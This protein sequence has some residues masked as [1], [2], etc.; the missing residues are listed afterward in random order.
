MPRP[1]LDL[2]PRPSSSSALRIALGVAVIVA[3]AILVLRDGSGRGIEIER[4]DPLPGVDEIRVE[5]GGAVAQP[6]VF[7][8]RPGDRVI[9]AIA[10][11]GGLAADA[12]TAPINLSRRL[13]D[14]DRVLVPRSGELPPLLDVNTA[15]AAQLDELPGIGAV[16]SAAIVSAR[17]LDGPFATTDDLVERG[18]IPE[19]VYEAIRDRIAAR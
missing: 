5:V 4:R 8:V 12:D 17:L 10:L 15:S 2:L 7:T 19:H 11:A 1:S 6:G 18:V 9:D 13:H 16:Y 3:F 14:E